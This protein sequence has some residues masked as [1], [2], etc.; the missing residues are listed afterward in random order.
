MSG[1]VFG[2]FGLSVP[3]FGF[4]VWGS[5]R[6]SV[7]TVVYHAIVGQPSLQIT[8]AIEDFQIMEIDSN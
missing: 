6:V 8:G 7:V 2:R 4:G 1:F 5:V 3:G